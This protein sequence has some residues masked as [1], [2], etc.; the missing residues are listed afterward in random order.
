MLAPGLASEIVTLCVAV[1]VPGAG[2]NAG[3]AAGGRLIVKVPEATALVVAPV[4]VAIALMVDV[5]LTV[6]GAT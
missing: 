1:N 6:M 4:A 3:V 2:E 5:A